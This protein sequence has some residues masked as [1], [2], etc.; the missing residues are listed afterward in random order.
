MS[1]HKTLYIEFSTSY[2]YT[3]K[4]THIPTE[5]PPQHTHTYP[6]NPH[7]HI[8][9]PIHTFPHAH[10]HIPARTHFIDVILLPFCPWTV[11]FGILITRGSLMKKE[12]SSFIHVPVDGVWTT[13]AKIPGQKSRDGWT[14]NCVTVRVSV[15]EMLLVALACVN[16]PFSM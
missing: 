8:Y 15:N 4:C 9:I 5:P 11:S 14:L 16:F 10:I 7:T 12:C 2:Y 3:H 13:A 6:P 1:H